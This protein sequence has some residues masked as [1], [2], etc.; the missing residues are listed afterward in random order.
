MRRSNCFF[1]AWWLWL[2]W[3]RKRGGYCAIRWTRPPIPY[4]WHWS[5]IPRGKRLR[6]IHFEPV[7]REKRLWRAMIHKL[8]FT[9]R[10]R[11]YDTEWR[12]D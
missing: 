4:G 12:G 7:R 3:S 10:I 6:T 11:R 5:Y 9:G 8:W 1:F 2:K